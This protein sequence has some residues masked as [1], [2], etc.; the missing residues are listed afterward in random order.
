MVNMEQ[1]IPVKEAAI[2]VVFRYWMGIILFSWALP[3][4]MDSGKVHEL[5]MMQAGINFLGRSA[6][7]NVD[8]KIGYTVKTITNTLTPP[9][10]SKAV[11]NMA[12]KTAFRSPNMFV[13][14]LEKTATRSVSSMIFPNNALETNTKKYFAIKPDMAVA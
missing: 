1:T 3:G 5:L 12:P 13:I 11:D 10:A 6:L 4:S 14:I 8:R 7:L 2:G 9:Y